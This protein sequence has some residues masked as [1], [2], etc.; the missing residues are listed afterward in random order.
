MTRFALGFAAGATVTLLAAI[1]VAILD[2][3]MPAPGTRGRA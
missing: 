3:Q 2:A 1:G